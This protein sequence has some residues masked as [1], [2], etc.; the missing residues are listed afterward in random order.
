MARL[1]LPLP[2]APCSCFRALLASLLLVAALQLLYL[3]L[4]SAMHGRQQRLRYSRLFQA[5]GRPGAALGAGAQGGESQSREALTL[6]PGR[7]DP[8][9]RYR[10]YRDV[11]RSPVSR[12]A[13]DLELSLATHSSLHNLHHLPGLARRWQ[14]PLAV[15]VFAGPGELSAS[16]QLI[17]NLEGH[18]PCLRGR[19]TFTLVTPSGLPEK[20]VAPEPGGGERQGPGTQDPQVG[21]P[22]D[23][24]PACRRALAQLRRYSLGRTN[25]ALSAG[26]YPNN[27]LRNA[28]RQALPSRHV[29]VIDVDMLPSAGLH[30]GFLRLLD[31]LTRS[32][33]SGPGADRTVYVVPAL[34]MRHTRRLPQHKAELQQLYQVAEVQPFYAELCPRCQAPTNYSR[35]INLPA[36]ATAATSTSSTGPALRVAYTREWTDPWEPF[37]ISRTTVPPYDERFEQYGFN[38]ISQACELHVAGYTFAVLDNAFLIHKGFKLASEFH[39]QKDEENRRN[40]ILFR[41]FKQDLKLKYPDSPRWC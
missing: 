40:R 35:W 32:A 16:L 2:R 28:A 12:E 22:P 37:Y 33:E 17:H 34:E 27:L 24:H 38:R 15:A 25:Y 19:V 4:L 11:S 36:A 23:P 9:G 31:D 5:G 39:P 6:G 41:Q 21:E 29:L 30:P 13:G 3:G 10:L 26:P 7:L 8:S 1:L 20:G 14:G 18:C